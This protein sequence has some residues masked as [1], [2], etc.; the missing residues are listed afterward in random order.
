MDMVA[1][2]C[3]ISLLT[4]A[5]LIHVPGRWHVEETTLFSLCK[6]FIE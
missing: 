6:T 1:S 3:P 5:R 4:I 2:D